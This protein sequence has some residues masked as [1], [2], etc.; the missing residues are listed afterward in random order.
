MTPESHGIPGHEGAGTVVKVGS[1]MEAKWKVGDRA[2]IKCT[3]STPT[4]TPI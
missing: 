4:A 3:F 2:G 1:G